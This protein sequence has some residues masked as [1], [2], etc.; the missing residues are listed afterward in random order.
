LVGY[1]KLHSFGY[2]LEFELDS[3]AEKE[4][5][6]ES[7]SDNY[8]EEYQSYSDNFMVCGKKGKV[9]ICENDECQ[10]LV[11]VSDLGV[12]SSDPDPEGW[13]NIY[14]CPNGR[15]QQSQDDLE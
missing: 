12:N 14:L 1:S 4:R 11:T 5:D 13:A 8:G 10:K 9:F 6:K 3:D 15:N 2:D 7:Q